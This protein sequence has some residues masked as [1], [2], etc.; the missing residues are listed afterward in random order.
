MWDPG[1]ESIALMLAGLQRA[2]LMAIGRLSKA[3]MDMVTL[4]ELERKVA[5]YLKQ[6]LQ[7]IPVPLSFRLISLISL[8]QPLFEAYKFPHG[9]EIPQMPG[10]GCLSI[11][12]FVF[13]SRFSGCRISCS[14]APGQK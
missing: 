11:A 8:L 12:T 9:L 13:G 3:T 2:C 14:S 7:Q 6:K 4:V 5:K 1:T 10:A